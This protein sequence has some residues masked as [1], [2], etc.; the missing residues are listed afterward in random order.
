[1]KTLQILN[2]IDIGFLGSL[3][4]THRQFLGNLFLATCGVY[5]VFAIVYSLS[6]IEIAE[7]T[8]NP[9]VNDLAHGVFRCISVWNYIVQIV[10]YISINI[11]HYVNRTVCLQHLLVRVPQHQRSHLPENHR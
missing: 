6:C 4:R 11:T 3:F 1:M 7:L 10:F 9:A 2:L 5:S 8:E